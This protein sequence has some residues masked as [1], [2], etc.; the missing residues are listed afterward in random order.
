MKK[1]ALI[2]DDKIIKYKTIPSNDNVIIPKLL[3]HRYRIVEEQPAPVHDYV[4]QTLSDSYEI[5]QDRV[6]RVWAVEE[7]SFDES[8]QTKKDIIEQSAL[9]KIRAVFDDVDQKAKV[10][11]ILTVKDF[12]VAEI[13]AA[14]NNKDLRA[15]TSIVEV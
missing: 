3:A 12:V 1:Y 2:Q 7:R 11:G 6:L 5:Q 14:K 15:I 10:E 4:T 9:N 13:E 8:Q